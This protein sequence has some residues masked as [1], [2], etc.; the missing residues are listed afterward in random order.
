MTTTDDASNTSPGNETAVFA[1]YKEASL[2]CETEK[3]EHIRKWVHTQALNIPTSKL[4]VE[5]SSFSKPSDGDADDDSSEK[6]ES[7]VP[8]RHQAPNLSSSRQELSQTA[9]ERPSMVSTSYSSEE[10]KKEVRAQE[11][12]QF[13]E[14]SD[15][16]SRVDANRIDTTFS[17]SF[18]FEQFSESE[19]EPQ[20]MNSSNTSNST[21]S[22]LSA[23][24]TEQKTTL[25]SETITS[26]K[27]RDRASDTAS[28]IQS[29]LH[30][31]NKQLKDLGYGTVDSKTDKDLLRR[32]VS[33]LRA[34]L[35]DV[36][37]KR[38]RFKAL[39]T[40]SETWKSREQAL[41][42][43]IKSLEL[44]VNENEKAKQLTSSNSLV[45]NEEQE[46]KIKRLQ[47]A[48]Q[49]LDKETKKSKNNENLLRHKLNESKQLLESTKS[50]LETTEKDNGELKSRI[51]T[52]NENNRSLEK[53][54]EDAQKQLRP[55]E[56][57]NRVKNSEL[58]QLRMNHEALLN[59]K[60]QL[61]NKCEKFEQ[62]FK[63]QELE[64]HRLK[65]ILE[66]GTKSQEAKKALQRVSMERSKRNSLEQKSEKLMHELKRVQQTGGAQEKAL[67]TKDDKIADL[68]LEVKKLKADCSLTSLQRDLNKTSE[69]TNKELVLKEKL[70]KLEKDRKKALIE[71]EEIRQKCKF[72]QKENLELMNQ[73]VE[74]ERIV[75]KLKSDSVRS[76]DDLQEMAYNLNKTKVKLKEVEKSLSSS[77]SQN[78]SN[79]ASLKAQKVDHSSIQ[80][81]IAE[82]TS[83]K[84]A[85]EH[86][87]HH[88]ENTCAKLKEVLKLKI[89]QE[90]RRNLSDKASF[91]KLQEWAGIHYH[92]D[93]RRSVSRG[94][95]F[96]FAEQKIR[97]L[98]E[99]LESMQ[100]EQRKLLSERR[101]VENQVADFRN[102]ETSLSLPLDKI[103]NR[104]R[105]AE[106]SITDLST[107]LI[108]CQE[109]KTK[110]LKCHTAE[111]QN[112]EKRITEQKHT[113][114][115]LQQQLHQRPTALASAEHQVDLPTPLLIQ[116][117][118]QINALERQL[119]E[120]RL[121]GKENHSIG[122]GL[123]GKIP[124]PLLEK[125]LK[126][127]PV[128]EFM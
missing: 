111:K 27:T 113:I 123:V 2:D 79:S 119:S 97:E 10:Y 39:L 12:S 11:H 14:S 32:L 7:S 21:S 60:G 61:T 42:T 51:R 121:P 62:A 56:N 28:C 25:K 117:I 101:E 63:T 90:E 127:S 77:E 107:K 36:D 87:V 85:L 124:R 106:K 37:Q 66:S 73:R 126:V 128:A 99:E 110:N 59:E 44:E 5:S 48:Q 78:A 89:E 120:R 114:Q 17:G 20:N 69:F 4:S 45:R 94:E 3:L 55:L 86:K 29:I 104:L 95:V 15:N 18:D 98:E 38:T 16:A 91:H 74:A 96:Q 57:S 72:L 46:R 65:Q 53:K 70:E 41:H 108:L 93:K 43:R 52:L 13:S 8:R 105:L 102:K 30:D 92:G 50:K 84:T 67:K 35:S 71:M 34:I 24:G 115:N 26:A 125:I 1:S 75:Q 64:T 81:E 9:D 23:F 40:A 6:Q 116:K 33:K 80:K 112:L 31:L 122:K 82:L 118:P 58:C 54:Y 22:F 68:E 76:A 88:L 103:Q 19:A 109:T 47:E 83:V 49:V 100:V